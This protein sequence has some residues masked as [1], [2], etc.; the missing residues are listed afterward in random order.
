MRPKLVALKR[1]DISA[2]QREPFSISEA[3]I[4]GLTA[5]ITL[6]ACRLT[7]TEPGNFPRGAPLACLESTCFAERLAGSSGIEELI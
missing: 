1:S 2:S 7:W 5:C 3:D 6:G 4:H